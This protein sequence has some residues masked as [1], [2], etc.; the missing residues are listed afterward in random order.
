MPSPIEGFGGNWT[1]WTGRLAG[2]KLAYGLDGSMDL[3]GMTYGI[4]WWESDRLWKAHPMCHGVLVRSGDSDFAMLDLCCWPWTLITYNTL[5]HWRKDIY[6]F[7]HIHIYTY[8][9]IH[10]CTYIH[11]YIYIHTHIHIDIYIYLC[12]L[13]YLCVCIYICINACIYIYVFINIYIDSTMQ[14]DITRK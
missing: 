3:N 5:Q 9:Q 13:I 6:T 12:V 8:T 4:R 14:R 7:T 10:I 11:V 1:R 2:M